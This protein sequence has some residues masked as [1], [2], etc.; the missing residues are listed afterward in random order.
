MS[1]LAA[2]G[3]RMFKRHL[4]VRGKQYTRIGK[5]AEEICKNTLEQL[6]NGRIMQTSLGHYN[7]FY[8]RDFG[9]VIPALL[10][11]GYKDACKATMEYALSA[12]KERG[13]ITTHISVDGKALRF[14]NVYSPDSVAYFLKSYRLVFGKTR[15]EDKTFL[16]QQVKHFCTTVLDNEGK[17][18]RGVHF[19]G[20][21]DHAVR[22]ASCYDTVMAAVVQR[23][24]ASL[25]L[26]F[27]HPQTDYAK[28][29]IDDY[30]TGSYF[31]DDSENKTMTADACIYPFWH[32]IIKDEEKLRKTVKTMQA[33]KLDRPFP[34][35]YVATAQDQGK[36]IWQNIFV[37]G[38]EADSIWPM[39]GLPFID[40]VAKIDKKQAKYYHIQYRKRI[41]K[42]GTFIELY[43]RKGKPY[44]SLVYSA[45]EGMIWCANWLRQLETF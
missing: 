44:T 38:W 5:H 7:Q 29:L 11:L 22:D 42:Y 19:G 36:N 1:S 6:W 43:D 31:Q 45:D 34:I 23:E 13:E 4:K 30:W 14:P 9:M 21:R 25:D 2:E 26:P 40:I 20:M 12:Y 10:E 15:K 3:W 28:I 24:C 17:I 32:G 41:Q 35:K 37:P 39:S 18:K 33:A 16:Q 27:M 8:S